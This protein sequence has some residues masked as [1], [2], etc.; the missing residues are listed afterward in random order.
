MPVTVYLT[1]FYYHY[2]RP[3]FDLMCSYLLWKA[4]RK[5]LDLKKL[6]GQDIEINLSSNDGREAVLTL[7][8]AFALIQKLS[9]DEK[10][11]FAAA[12]AKQLRVD[13]DELIE[14]RILHNLTAT[15]VSK[16]AGG[17]I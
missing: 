16:G 1:T 10:D 13:Y 3:V 2:Q 4:R 11:A 7:I 17:G 5:A 6:T 9:A 12:M 14:Q 15:E 8:H